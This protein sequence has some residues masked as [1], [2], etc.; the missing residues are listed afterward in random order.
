[1]EGGFQGISARARSVGVEAVS[2][3]VLSVA[4]TTFGILMIILGL[5]VALIDRSD[6]PRIIANQQKLLEGERSITKTQQETIE[7]QRRTIA[8]YQQIGGSTNE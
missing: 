7:I 2:T 3:P 6:Q 1:M 5:F 4:C 8:A